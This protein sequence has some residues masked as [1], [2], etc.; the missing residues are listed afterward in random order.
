MKKLVI[1]F[2]TVMLITVFTSCNG[3]V[4]NKKNV[5]ANSNASLKENVTSTNILIDSSKNKT[6][7]KIKYIEVKY[8][9]SFNIPKEELEKMPPEIKASFIEML[10]ITPMFYYLKNNGDESTYYSNFISSKENKTD[11]TLI[12][13]KKENK[14][15]IKLPEQNIY[16]NFKESLLIQQEELND[17]KYIISKKLERINWKITSEVKKIDVFQCKKATAIIKGEKITAWFT[18]EIAI[19]DGPSFYWGLPGLILKV[20]ALDRNYI[21]IEIKTKEN[22]DIKKISTGKVITQI[23]YDKI[24]KKLK[25][26]QTTTHENIAE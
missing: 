17:N 20:E 10:H 3:Q 12:D 23:E 13:K 7:N 24:I 16:K 18:E 8:Q 26:N 11:V 1:F 4:T 15:I 22:L 14:T 6:S 21:T 5:K 9:E 2:K 25:E 19:N